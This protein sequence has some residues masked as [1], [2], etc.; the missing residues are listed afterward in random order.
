MKIEIP[1]KQPFH[2]VEQKEE[3]LWILHGNKLNL[4]DVCM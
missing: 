4:Q 3:N 2:E 1:E